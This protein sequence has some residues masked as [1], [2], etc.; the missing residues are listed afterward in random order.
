MT[1]YC[2]YYVHARIHNASKNLV[3]PIPKTKI[4]KH[5]PKDIPKAPKGYTLIK[6]SEDA[7]V[8]IVTDKVYIRARFL[9]VG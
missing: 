7:G 6:N 4:L 5:E 9:K 3:M 8:C 1:Q 2:R